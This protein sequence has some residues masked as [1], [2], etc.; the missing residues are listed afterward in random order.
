MRHPRFLRVTTTLAQQARRQSG[1]YHTC[2]T[3]AGWCGQAAGSHTTSYVSDAQCNL[4]EVIMAWPL[5][6]AE[7]LLTLCRAL[8]TSA[9]EVA[10]LMG[11]ELKGLSALEVMRKKSVNA[12]RLELEHKQEEQE[13]QEKVR[14]AASSL[15]ARCTRVVYATLRRAPALHHRAN[16]L[17]V[18]A[19]VC[20]P[21]GQ[22]RRSVHSL[23]LLIS[24]QPPSCNSSRH[25]TSAD[26]L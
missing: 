19:V 22:R 13:E 12:G 10:Q 23:R 21:G 9:G 3:G 26:L 6:E 17:H 8:G 18:Y 5:S 15:R 4:G 2:T 1:G 24:A 7:K 14:D 25:L 20:R 11:E 16:R